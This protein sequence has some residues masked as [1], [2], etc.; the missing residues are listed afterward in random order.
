MKMLTLFCVIACAFG[1]RHISEPRTPDGRHVRVLTYN[2]NWGGPG[3]EATLEII[4]HSGADIVCLQE[5][6]PEWER[7]IAAAL[8]TNYPVAEFRSSAGRMGGG[9]G[10]LARGKARTVAYIPSDSGWFDGWIMAFETDVGP[11]QVLNVHLRPPVSDNGSWVS[12][13]FSTRDDRLREIERFYQQRA[14]GIPILVV[15]DFN[16]GEDSRAV[17]WLQAQGMTNALPQFDRK[18]PTWEWPTSVV[19]LRRRMD[20]IT[21][22]HELRCASARVIHA[23]ESDHFPV[24]AVFDRSNQ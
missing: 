21:Y 1:C 6:T 5:T 23:G 7:Y 14:P 11:V 18:S 17:K 24:E 15:G 13:Y 22:S 12:G 9:L 16:D 4:R 19:T 8:R 20:H 3:A 2:V 10:F